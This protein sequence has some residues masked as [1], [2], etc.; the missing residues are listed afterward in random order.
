MGSVVSG[1]AGHGVICIPDI[2][3]VRPTFLLWLVIVVYLLCF[4]QGLHLAL[5]LGDMVDV[6]CGGTSFRG[7]VFVYFLRRAVP[8]CCLCR[9]TFVHRQT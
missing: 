4:L 9:T 6:R 1:R 7:F 8:P 2:T 5:L 3:Y